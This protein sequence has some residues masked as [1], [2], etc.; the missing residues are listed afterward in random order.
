MKLVFLFLIYCCLLSVEGNVASGR[1]ALSARLK[2]RNS[3]FGGRRQERLLNPSKQTQNRFESYKNTKGENVFQENYRGG[4]EDMDLTSEYSDTLLKKSIVAANS[5]LFTFASSKYLA[6]I[7]FSLRSVTVSLVLSLVA[8]VLTYVPGEAGDFCRAC[9]VFCILIL[10]SI[11]PH[12]FFVSLGKQLGVCFYLTKRQPFPP[13]E[14]PWQYNRKEIDQPDFRMTRVLVTTMIA[15][16]FLGYL[17]GR[18]IPYFP[19]WAGALGVSCVMGVTATS[20]DSVGDLV[21]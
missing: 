17:A 6:E 13:C 3:F 18:E 10:R 12:N 4:D 16:L 5:F 9:G 21:R 20:K 15:G 19:T 1:I 7:L 8:F 11:H 14:N 2:Q